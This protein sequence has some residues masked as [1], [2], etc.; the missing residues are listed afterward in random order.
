MKSKQK[1]ERTCRKIRF[2]DRYSVGGLRNFQEKTVVKIEKWHVQLSIV[3]LSRN[4]INV[5][6]T[7]VK[8]R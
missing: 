1:H 8:S 4:K 5:A 7:V 6:G 3:L 2:T